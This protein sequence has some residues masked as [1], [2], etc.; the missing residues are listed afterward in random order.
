MFRIRP[1]L[2]KENGICPI[3]AFPYVREKRTLQAIYFDNAYDITAWTLRCAECGYEMVLPGAA[4]IRAH[5]QGAGRSALTLTATALLPVQEAGTKKPKAVQDGQAEEWKGQD[6]LEVPQ[7]PGEA[8]RQ[9]AKEAHEDAGAG[10]AMDNVDTADAEVPLE[11]HSA[12]AKESQTDGTGRAA[13]KGSP[14][15]P[16]QSKTAEMLGNTEAK[17][18]TSDAKDVGEAASADT[19]HGPDG[20]DSKDSGNREAVPKKVPKAA[21]HTGHPADTGAG[22]AKEGTAT[23]APAGQVKEKCEGQ[24]TGMQDKKLHGSKELDKKRPG[25]EATAVQER[26]GRQKNAAADSQKPHTPQAPPATPMP[27]GRQPGT[28]QPGFSGSG[29]FSPSALSNLGL[30]RASVHADMGMQAKGQ[31]DAVK[32]RDAGQPRAA[33]GK[34]RKTAGSGRMSRSLSA[35]KQNLEEL[36]AQTLQQISIQ[37][38]LSAKNQGKQD[39]KCLSTEPGNAMTGTP[40]KKTEEA[41]KDDEP[42]DAVDTKKSTDAKEVSAIPTAP[43]AAVSPAKAD[44]TKGAEGAGDADGKKSPGPEPDREPKP[45][46]DTKGKASDLDKDGQGAAREPKAVGSQGNGDPVDE[47]QVGGT[48]ETKEA[49]DGK[50]EA[51]E[52]RRKEKKDKDRKDLKGQAMETTKKISDKLPAD[53]VEKLP[54]ISQISKQQ[55]HAIFISEEKRFLEQ[56]IPHKQV[57][58]N[59]LIYDTDNSEMFLRSGGRY[60]L[61]QPCVHY[62]YRTKNGN[63]FR[64][65]VK[66]KQE[67]SIRPLDMIE[68]K[69]MLEE[70]PNL[71]KKFFPDSVNDA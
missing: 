16:V 6:M 29:M 44:E 10:A 8:E 68:A 47:A 46:Q 30:L 19:K 34:D 33:R 70:H 3:C 60:G 40:T 15:P 2:K 35:D 54:V 62:N 63:F 5:A 71:Y 1:L 22:E 69:R 55:K 58:I 25:Q 57:I 45:V 64:C 13:H 65:T 51:Q 50:E 7:K 61:D 39:G 18:A 14:E 48:Q 31:T 12:A 32:G 66:Y 38:T 36:S 24:E 52:A 41:R 27:K 42:V 21:P 11:A 53:L 23:P 49:M 28:F 56:H 4:R 37:K 59:D 17:E 26:T 9:E 20:K 43:A 67:D